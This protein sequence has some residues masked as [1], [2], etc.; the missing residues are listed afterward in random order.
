M[1]FLPAKVNGSRVELPFG[2]V[3]I[4]E[5]KAAKAQGKDLLIAGIRPDHFEDAS[6]LDGDRAAGDSTF[7]AQVDVVEWLGNE[8]YA[9]IPFE[10]PPEVQEQLTQLEKDLDG[11]SMRT[12]LVVSL[13][14][15][16]KISEGDQAKIWVDASKIHLFDPST[17]ENLTMDADRAGIVPGRDAMKKADEAGHAQ[18]SVQT[19]AVAEE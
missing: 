9:Y 1:N 12:Q 15:A 19:S 14:G 18:D 7:D 13:D 16:S 6:V 11:E 2:T 10:A 4:P 17:G 3:T 5:E 8:A